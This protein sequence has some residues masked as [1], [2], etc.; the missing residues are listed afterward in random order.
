MPGPASKPRELRQRRNKKAEAAAL[1]T[2]LDPKIPSIPNP[3]KRKWH[4]LTRAWWKHI[5]Q[6]PMATR[7]LQT[8]LDALGLVAVLV[9]DFHASTSVKDRKDLA[10][11][12]RMW[13]A[14]FGLSNWDRNR[15]DWTVTAAPE[16]KP[17]PQSQGPKVLDPRTV[18]KAL[19]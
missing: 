12:I 15:M 10:M 18:L 19:K 16:N 1:T 8:D 17:R 2:P 6:S 11:E 13:T 3:D 4:R 7:Y 9:D 14:R 5:W